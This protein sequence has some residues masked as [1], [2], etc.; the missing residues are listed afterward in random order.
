[1]NTE[2]NKENNKEKPEIRNFCN[3]TELFIDDFL[4][5]MISV[6]DQE[7][8]EAHIA[9]CE[10]C[11]KYMDD[12]VELT[13]KISALGSAPVNLS[14]NK[15]D[16]LWK[17]VEAGTDF[18]KFTNRNSVKTKK[19][20]E[21]D[22][23]LVNFISKYKYYVSGLAA[24]IV[25]GVIIFGV[26]NMQT[27]SDRLAQQNTFGLASYWKV[28]NLEGNSMIGDVSMTGNDSIKEGQ[29]IQ[30][31]AISRAELMVANLGKV[32]I[33]PNSRIVFVK[34]AEG[35]NRIQVEYGTIQTTMNPNSKSFFVEMPSAVATDNGGSYTITVDSTGDGLVFV[36]S[37]KVEVE[38][39]N[40]EAV[41]PAGSIVLT[42]KN[43]GVGTPFNENSSPQFKN[44]LFNF[45]FGKCND[46]CVNTLLNNAKMSDAVTLVNLMPNVQGVDKEKVYTK[47]VNFVPPPNPVHGDSIYFMDEKKLNEWIDKIQVE[48]QVNVEKSMKEVEKSLENLKELETMTPENIEQLKN[49]AKDWKFQIHTSPKG[50]Y[51]WE[52][53]TVEFNEEEFRQDMEEMK[54]E[55][56]ENSFNKEQLKIDMQNL[57]EDLKEMQI[58]LKENLNLNNEE[59]K[60]E[61]KKAN[62]EI[63]KAMENEN[64]QILIDSAIS[65]EKHKIKVQVK[66]NQESDEE[67]D[68]N[69]IE[70]ENENENDN[71]SEINNNA[72]DN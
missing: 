60:N 36:K 37:G 45:D 25:V 51:V 50:A 55:L 11:K 64:F 63:K 70:N 67:Q 40:R 72:P 8:M 47:L 28:S 13:K 16:E 15:K 59:L 49:F 3:E 53:D 4:D 54:Q 71:D 69:I 18:N 68:E 58:E 52:S 19:T 23:F 24:L 5:G 57:K 14:S 26:K 34:N 44:A 42:K 46:A 2:N 1:M 66:N 31:D 7:K 17:Q 9:K 62:E 6:K 10:F 43:Y 21:E 56:K 12:S 61:L 30:T 38:S 35:N 41:I 48:V 29:W 32:I 22:N 27:S 33:E 20:S 39:P 65:S